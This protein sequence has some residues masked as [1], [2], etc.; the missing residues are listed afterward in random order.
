MAEI[1]NEQQTDKYI[2]LKYAEFKDGNKQSERAENKRSGCQGG[3]LGGG[4]R[5]A[6]SER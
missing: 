4:D 1:K 6:E 5:K 3:L 2:T